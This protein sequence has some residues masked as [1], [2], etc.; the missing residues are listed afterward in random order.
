MTLCKYIKGWIFGTA[1]VT[2]EEMQGIKHHMI[3]IAKP[4]ERYSVSSYKKQAEICI[5]EILKRGK[6]PIVVRRD[7]T[8][9]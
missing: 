7:W 9:Y 8:I 4:N 1:K 6:A 2:V 3:D 5:E